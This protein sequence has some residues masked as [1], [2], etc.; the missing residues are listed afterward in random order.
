MPEIIMPRLSDTME[1][2]TL[3]RWFKREG[4]MVHRG[5]VIAEIETDKASMELEA[6]DE[7]PLTR[8]LVQEGDTVP[9]G[10]PIAVIGE[11]G[12]AAPAEAAPS[13]EAPPSE[14]PSAEAPPA[15]VEAAPEQRPQAAPDREAAPPEPA[16]PPQAPPGRG[17]GGRVPTSPLARRIA[18]EHGI[19]ITTIK[20][21]GPGGR[22]VRA[23]VEAAIARREQEKAAPPP[24]AAPAAPAAERPAAAPAG[25]PIVHE[26]E[27]PSLPEDADEVPLNRMRRL[28][29]QRLTR[30]V[31]EAPHFYLTSVVDAEP[32]LAYRAELN[33]ALADRGPKITI[34]DLILKACAV[35][36]REHRE[37]NAS[38]AETRIL[39]H[40]RVNLGLAVA[41][42]DG[43]IVPVI[44]DADRK[45]L[46]EIAREA[47]DLAQRAR[48]GKLTLDELAGGTFTVSNLG[49]FGIDH[50]TAVINP[51]Q[52]AILAVGAAKP[53]PVV[54]DGEVRPG[55]TMALTLSIDHRVLDGATGA[56]Y[57]A[58][59]KSLLEQ[60]VRIVV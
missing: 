49:P 31:Q 5:D 4:E 26:T 11:G 20:G 19:D 32:L 25:R 45:T 54:R 58:D 13:A 18:R 51:P 34:T 35:M 14:A 2:G 36:L 16:V 56:A 10:T 55:V 42:D 12:P 53:Q 60:P 59:L 37:L 40:H 3:S 41:L 6:Y 39:R 7:G 29:A 23:D 57:L 52:A 46:T 47:H 1:E 27:A 8:I 24:A 30:S 17:P 44:H 28:T 15:E 38:W 50:F 22:I 9:I 33:A 21:S 43:L 48:T